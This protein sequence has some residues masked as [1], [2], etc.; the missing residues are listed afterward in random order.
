MLLFLR[1][2]LIV[3]VL[4]NLYGCQVLGEEEDSSSKQMILIG[5]VEPDNTFLNT[6][7]EGFQLELVKDGELIDTKFLRRDIQTN[8][9]PFEFSIFNFS[10]WNITAYSFCFY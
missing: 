9:Y 3:W 4:V 2:L 8:T 7:P 6:R 10:D 1:L 5:V